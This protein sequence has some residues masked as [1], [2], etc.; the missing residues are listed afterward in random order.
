MSGGQGSAHGGSRVTGRQEVRRRIVRSL[1]GL[2][3]KGET[4]VNHMFL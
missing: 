4:I 2:E 3:V 1:C